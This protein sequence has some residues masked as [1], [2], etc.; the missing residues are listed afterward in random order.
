[1]SAPVDSESKWAW[2]LTRLVTL[3]VYIF[4]FAPILA[5]I[6]LSFN[7]SMFGGFPMTGFS[8]RWYGKLL[9]NEQVVAAFKTSLWIAVVTAIVTTFIGVLT[10]LALVRF[11]FR[12][13][14]MLGTLVILPA[15]VPET[16]LGVGLLILIKAID[17]PRTLPILVLGHILLALPYVVLIA[18]ARMVGVRRIYEE[19]AMSMGASRLDAFR[20]ITL[21]L[22]IPAVAAG[23]LLAFTISFDNTSAS[24]FWRPAGV[25]T[26]PT[27]ILSM[28]KTSISPEV[29]ALGT[30][31]IVMTVGIPLMGG[32]L[33]QGLARL[34]RSKP[35][36]D[37]K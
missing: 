30:V 37:A 24:L 16:I 13:K 21:P 7:A 33:A 4:M 28:L 17:Q 34:K 20:E 5:T 22:L 19:A 36:E 2:R 12:G 9:E 3:C 31:M 25:E 32:L 15:L 23:A 26:M 6:V 27:Q 10:S 8:L 14:E 11:D 35:R 18:Q 1:M 29:N